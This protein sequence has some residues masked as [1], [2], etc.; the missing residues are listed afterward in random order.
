VSTDDS[1]AL[2]AGAAIAVGLALWL[3]MSSN[4]IESNLQALLNG[5]PLTTAGLSTLASDYGTGLG[6]GAKAGAE[7]GGVVPIFGTAIGLLV[8][9]G[10]GGLA[11]AAEGWLAPNSPNQSS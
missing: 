11:G 1:I 6:A 10:L 8:G 4:G 9:G 5:D 2:I 7:I 3:S